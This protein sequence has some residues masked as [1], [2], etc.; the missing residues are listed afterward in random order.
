[1]IGSDAFCPKTGAPLSDQRHYDGRGRS[2]RSVVGDGLGVTTPTEG[3]LTNGAVR[4][5]APA[6]TRYFIR[7]QRR[8]GE[9]DAA[10]YRRASLAI[11]QL[12]RAASGREESDVHVWYAL[13]HR[14]RR[15][16]YPTEWM[17]SHIELRCPGCHG[18]LKYVDHGAG[19]TARC[20]TNC[21]G[22]H[23]DRL[24]EIRAVVL[25]LY[26]AAFPDDEGELSTD[27]VLRF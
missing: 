14:L 25:A 10:L 11:R 2:Y 24:E 8:Y 1:M 21:D 5:A 19:V 17:H 15:F 27:D 4:S 13:R 3:E 22:H 12:K 9:P 23:A 16:G 20:G 18:R 7:C 26:A 6:L